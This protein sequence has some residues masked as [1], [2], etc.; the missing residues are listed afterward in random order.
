MK[1]IYILLSAL[2][3]LIT[4]V[5]CDD[6]AQTP[7]QVVP[8]KGA[9][10][11]K[12]GVIGPLS[13]PDKDW[14]ESGL[15]GIKTA[16]YLQPYLENGRK[17]ELISEDD[18]NDP[19]LAKKA[20]AKLVNEEH[21]SS[22]IVMSNSE[23]VLNLRNIA[24]NL[25]TPILAIA[26]THPDITED[27]SYISQ[28][29][30]DDNFQASVAASFVID[31]LLVEHA[32]VMIDKENPHSLYL[33][34]QFINKFESVGG[35][36]AEISFT[37]D[38]AL[39]QKNLE[40]LKNKN[41][42]LL[43]LPLDA[44]NAVATARLL[45]AI[46]WKPII[47]GSDMLQATILLQHQESLDLFDGMLATDPYTTLSPQTNYGKSVAK[48]YR[49]SFESPGTVLAAAGCEGASIMFSAINRCQ[50]SED[51][52]CINSMLR[53]THDFLGIFGKISIKENGK[54][55]RA[56]FINTINGRHLQVVVKVY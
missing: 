20:L 6:T 2:F 25:K 27:N 16:T 28:L 46:N 29:L 21:V 11:I 14:G 39:L 5:S 18:Q 4:S 9:D 41:I 13:G 17:I 44:D 22:V 40:S 43:Y 48:L 23:S 51:K 1:T 12:I 47:L 36:I 3:L 45:D 19:I 10:P 42:S 53:T 34:K 49:K 54:S 35:V 26:A 38:S 56:I 50:N 37:S 55:E 31:E 24:E 33:A 30:F 32:A 8:V 7:K 15:S 52:S